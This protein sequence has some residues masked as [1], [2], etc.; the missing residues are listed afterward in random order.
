M[1]RAYH[2]PTHIEHALQLLTRSGM[3]TAILAGQSLLDA[4]LGDVVDELVDLQ[5]LGL[6]RIQEDG[7]RLVVETLVPLQ[8]LMEHGAVPDRLRALIHAEEAHTFRNMRTIGSLLYAPDAESQLLAALLVCDAAVD[9]ET[10]MG[11]K[12]MPLTE[13][14]SNLADSLDDGIPIA[15]SLDTSGRIA[16]AHVARTPADKPIVAA[17]A[18]RGADG[19]VRLALSGVASMP[20]LID[21]AKIEQ[22]QPAG[23]FRGS[24]AY[25][26]EMA[27]ILSQRVLN[28][29]G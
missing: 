2:R 28:E 17:V 19:K 23:D 29:V 4:P 24:T 16:A 7:A 15:V 10:L 26:R 25:R 21:N 18:R 22:L 8:T 5:A 9:V 6:K 12:Q 20:L 1:I 11:T 14:L 3:K 13:F 27:L